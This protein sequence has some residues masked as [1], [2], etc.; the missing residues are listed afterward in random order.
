MNVKEVKILIGASDISERNR[1][2]FYYYFPLSFWGCKSY[3]VDECIKILKNSIDQ[4]AENIEKLRIEEEGNWDREDQS[5]KN[6]FFRFTSLEYDLSVIHNDFKPDSVNEYVNLKIKDSWEY[7][8]LEKAK[9]LIV[10]LER[11]KAS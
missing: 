9:T 1:S 6:S 8:Q 5:K 11:M 2:I 3:D 4:Y 10:E 7:Q